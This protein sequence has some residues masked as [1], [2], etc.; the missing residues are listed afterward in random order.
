[1]VTSTVT[2]PFSTDPVLKEEYRNPW[3]YLR[4]GKLLEDLDSLAGSVAFSHCDDG[5]PNT[6]PPMLVT[7]SVDAIHLRHKLSMDNDMEVSGRV[8][9]TGKSALD[10]QMELTQKQYGDEASLVALFTF[11]ARDPLDHQAV[12]INPLRPAISADEAL[13]AERQRVADERRA[14]RKAASQGP[15]SPGAEEHAARR[16]ADSQLAEARAIIDLPAL[17]PADAILMGATA[18]HNT[19]T[20]QPQVR[21]MSGRVFG[22]FL[23]RRAFELAFATAYT[24]AGWRPQFVRCEEVT[25]QRPVEVGDLLQLRCNVMHTDARHD[26]G[27]GTIHTQVTASVTKPEA[28]CSTVTNTFHFVFS[29]ELAGF[30]RQGCRLLRRVLPATEE[31]A[32]RIWAFCPVA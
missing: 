21:N 12:A 19:F 1:M 11:V 4:M 14:A 13:F 26:L 18:M 24:F 10:I 32:R 22:G 3:N 2:Y 25:F 31:E 7:A 28:V 20:C 5:L 9:W 16:W 29:T 17:A 23:M 27:L 6:R 15:S 30:R 8:V